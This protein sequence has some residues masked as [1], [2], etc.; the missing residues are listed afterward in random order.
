MIKAAFFDIDGTLA[1][2]R[3]HRPAP[4]TLDAL[5]RA[6]RAGLL[7]FICTGRHIALPHSRS[8]I[9]EWWELFDGFAGLNGQ[10]CFAADGSEIFSLPLDAGDVRRLLDVADKQHLECILS[11]RAR[12]FTVGPCRK[13]RALGTD[14]DYPVPPQQEYDGIEPVFALTFAADATQERELIAPQLRRSA[15][16]R[17]NPAFFDIIHA[18]GGK[19]V[20]LEQL[21]R[22]F[23]IDPAETIAFG[24]E[25]NDITM[26][27]RAGIGVAMGNAAAPVKA[28]ADYVTGRDEDGGVCD[29]LEHFGLI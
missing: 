19:D 12:E 29:A 16:S 1:D 25:Q 27:R 11:L 26:L 3:T 18:D 8:V 22:R 17:W 28:A 20:G 21:A 6:R 7:L 15:V 14:F 9:A 5:R 13:L 4:R 2:Y 10:H 23:G 24:D